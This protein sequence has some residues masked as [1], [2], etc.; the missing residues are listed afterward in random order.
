MTE[1][2]SIAISVLAL[3]ISGVA[4]WLAIFQRPPT[5][6]SPIFRVVY[7]T[8]ALMTGPTRPSA[9]IWAEIDVS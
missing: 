9:G 5:T 7:L 4:A 1:Y 3:G 6:V 8:I 2:I